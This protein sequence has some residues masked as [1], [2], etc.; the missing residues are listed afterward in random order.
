[1]NIKGGH[2][3]INP[4][5][6]SIFAAPTTVFTGDIATQFSSTKDLRNKLESNTENGASFIKLT[7]DNQS[8]ICGNGPIPVYTD[9]HL[10]IIFN[11]AEKRNL[12]VAAHNH[13]KYGFDR[14][15]KYPV[16]S[17]EHLVFD[18]VLSDGDIKKLQQKKASIVP[19]CV[20]ASCLAF[21]EVY[22]TLPPQFNTD[23]IKTEMRIKKEY[24]KTLASRYCEKAIHGY[25]MESIKHYKHMNC[26]SLVKDKKFIPDPILYF[27]MLKDGMENIRKMREAGILIGCGTDAGIPFD[28]FGSLWYEMEMMHR[29][30]FSK[31]E[32]LRC[33]TIN[34]A[35]IIG[36]GD[37]I[38][39]L[40]KGK[41]ADISIFNEN[42]LTNIKAYR[43]PFL[44]FKDG[45]LL[46]SN[47]PLLRQGNRLNFT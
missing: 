39:S 22:D 32:V 25:N 26:A 29:V 2:P 31:E 12:P 16:N 15:M 23:F 1:M 7:V 17:L 10:K 3:D 13:F 8:L 35:K 33:A 40:E 11:F 20:V 43:E 38:G 42:P 24:L 5:D 4:T 45:K 6:I 19:T 47:K 37:K 30:G 34:N 46:Y 18:T 14:I 21:D 44:V 9:E 27:G 41:F 28:Y 36:M